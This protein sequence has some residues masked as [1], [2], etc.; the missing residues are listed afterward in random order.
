MSE[1]ITLL[2]TNAEAIAVS[3]AD[4]QDI[5]E[6]KD[7]IQQIVLQLAD[8][9]E[10]RE[11]LDTKSLF[12]AGL[13]GARVA[14]VLRLI[15]FEAIELY[16]KK[17]D[18][19]EFKEAVLALRARIHPAV[20]RPEVP[21]EDLEFYHRLARCDCQGIDP[22][23]ARLVRLFQ[24]MGSAFHDIFY[25][26]DLK[27]NL[28]F[29]NRPGLDVLGFTRDDL[30]QGFSVFDIIVPEVLEMI[31]AR[32]KKAGSVS[33][34]PYAGEIC[35]KDGTRIP[36]E[37]ITR[38]MLC[39][40]EVV[41]VI[42]FARDLRLARR[43]EN[44]IR[45]ANNYLDNIIAHIPVGVIRTDS[46][47]AVIEAN[48]A[49]ALLY[50]AGDSSAL[51]GKPLFVLCEGE[52]QAVRKLVA[53]AV[54][55]KHQECG[56]IVEKTCFG[57]HLNAD[58]TVIPLQENSS[59][60]NG[61]L[62]LISQAA[63]QAASQETLQE[64]LILTEKLNTL[65]EIVSNVAHEL[66]NPLTAIL[67]YTQL[68]QNAK[69]GADPTSKLERLSKEAERCRAM[70][71]NLRSFARRYEGE[72]T[73]QDINELLKSTIALREYQLRIDEVEL[74]LDLAPDLPR[75]LANP[76]EL[77]RAFLSIVNN[78]HQAL[79]DAD[80]PAKKISVK[81]WSEKDSVYIK[82]ADNGPGIP[83][84]IQSRVFD[85]SFTTK[86]AGKGTGMG[87]TIVNDVI[88]DHNGTISIDSKEGEGTA[89]TIVLPA[90]EES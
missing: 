16:R 80:I 84:T 56:H 74:E 26:H 66:N 73:P 37:I 12:E 22:E 35:S 13:D 78:A 52:N 90:T 17:L 55:A 82:I 51:I 76:Y 43:F 70:I 23:F 68:L 19:I 64:N 3:V 58:F 27:G 2:R 65:T 69:P 32:L 60:E 5:D 62:L 45:R 77:Q 10:V 47:Y 48:P 50:G 38:T 53:H 21:P 42:G 25:L 36:V 75:V 44:E 6:H 30:I 33:R 40:D 61:V 49:A 9:L 31:E 46:Q 15:M 86:E 24:D 29:V 87:L 63:S 7:I 89:F 57:A 85:P 8:R 11:P 20:P 28:L 71:D 54:D 59:E 34:A 41:G 81:S 39:D 4:R 18:E 14:K 79:V 67:G 83:Q 72:K 1:H 88:H